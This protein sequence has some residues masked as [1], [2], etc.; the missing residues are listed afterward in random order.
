MILAKFSKKL[1]FGEVVW[2]SICT[3]DDVQHVCK[4]KALGSHRKQNYANAPNIDFRSVVLVGQNLL[5]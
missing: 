5:R 1:T 4:R 2:A 3:I